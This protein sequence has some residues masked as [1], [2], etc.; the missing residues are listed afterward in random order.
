MKI[1]DFIHNQLRARL[2]VG[3]YTI[4]LWAPDY[5]PLDTTIPSTQI[6]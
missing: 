3:K 1:N 6:R 2:P 5:L 4:T